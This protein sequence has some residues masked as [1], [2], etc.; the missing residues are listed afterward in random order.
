VGRTHRRYL[1]RRELRAWFAVN[2]ILE[3]PK[4]KARPFGIG[5][6]ATPEDTATLRGV[7]ERRLPKQHTSS[8]ARSWSS[9]TPYPDLPIIVLDDWAQFRSIDFSPEL[10]GRTWNG[11]D[12]DELLLGRYLER[13]ERTLRSMAPSPPVRPRRLARLTSRTR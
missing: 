8:T 4:L 12:P 13:I 11:W 9:A 2:A 10:Y 6:L 7:Q 3:H 1:A 5:A